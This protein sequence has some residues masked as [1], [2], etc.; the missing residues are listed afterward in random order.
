ETPSN[1]LLRVVDIAAV[2]AG[3]RTVDALVCVDNTFLS[4]ALQ[5]PLTLGADLVVHSTTKYLNGHS[6][7]V[8]GAV[9][10]RDRDLA[11]TVRDWSN[12]LGLTGAPFDAYLTLRGVRTL[13][14]RM[15]SH[16]ENAHALA[17]LLDRDERVLKVYYPGLEHSPFHALAN[18]QQSGF[19]G[20]I[21]FDLDTRHV[22]IRTFAESLRHF[23][24][25][26]SLGGV[27]SLVCHPSSMTHAPLSA[28]AKAVAGIGE[29]LIRLSVGIERADD[30]V[31]DI[32]EA[33]DRATRE[34]APTLRVA[35]V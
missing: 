11:N 1:P 17:D 10:C 28:E 35:S 26:E 20:M 31:A 34:A 9:V 2:V 23:S 18:V 14:A 3:A 16:E 27:E 33:L 7:V 24:L 19:G 15:R 13:H 12:N 29:G 32:N 30:L 6:D 25:A 8:G 4:P 21:S 22:C 5:Q